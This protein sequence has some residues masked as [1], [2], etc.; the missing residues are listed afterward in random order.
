MFGYIR[1]CKPELRMKEYDSYRA[2]YCG[3][4]RQMGKSFG[5]FARLVLSYDFA[6]LCMLSYA[7]SQEDAPQISR[8][9]CCVNPLNRVPMCA[10]DKTM[11]HGANVA[12]IMI[13]YKIAD[14]IYDNRGISRLGWKMMRL[15]VKPA[16]KKAVGACPEED[17]II[18]K[19]MKDQQRVESDPQYSGTDYSSEPTAQATSD[20]CAVMSDDVAQKRILERFGYLLGRY[21]YL[22][23]AFDDMEDDKKHRRYNPFLIDGQSVEETQGYARESLNLTIAEAGKACN[24]LR[25]SRYEQV[26]RN[27]VEL[28]L[29]SVSEQICRE[30]RSPDE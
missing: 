23:D 12:I 20:L 30:R 26:I 5:P 2:V 1:P 18:A 8:C 11:E 16:W 14:N 25:F 28:G 9:R 7:V 21:I 3:L 24:L 17:A 10:S 22:C 19:A 27:V 15:I 6:F 29:L 4:C 13:Y